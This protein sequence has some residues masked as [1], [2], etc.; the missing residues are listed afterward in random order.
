MS[1]YLKLIVVGILLLN[2]TAHAQEWGEISDEELNM[3]R[4][5]EDLNAD[6]IILFDKAEMAIFGLTVDYKR[7]IRIKIF[8]EKG[9]DKANVSIYFPEWYNLNELEAK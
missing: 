8:T 3:E 9:K 7:H 5:K 2:S 6:A 4:P 1:I